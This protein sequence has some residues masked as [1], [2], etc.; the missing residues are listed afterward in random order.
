MEVV[1][2]SPESTSTPSLSA[3]SERFPTPCPVPPHSL[4]EWTMNL[5]TGHWLATFQCHRVY[6]SSY[7]NTTSFFFRPHSLQSTHQWTTLSRLHSSLSQLELISLMKFYSS[8][9]GKANYNTVYVIHLKRVPKA[10]SSRNDVMFPISGET[11]GKRK[12]HRNEWRR[13]SG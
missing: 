7:D 4:I 1:S 13:A 3:K 9:H 12:T 2:G 11:G 5:A 10:T 6:S 8:C